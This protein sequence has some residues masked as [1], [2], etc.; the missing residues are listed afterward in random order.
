MSQHNSLIPLNEHLRNLYNEA[1]IQTGA[2]AIFFSSFEASE[3]VMRKLSEGDIRFKV[4][5]GRYDMQYETSYTIPAE[6]LE[7]LIASTLV[8]GQESLMLLNL[9]GEGF[10]MYNQFDANGEL[11]IE[12]LGEIITISKDDALQ[13]AAFTFDPEDGLYYGTVNKAA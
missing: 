3:V 2:V 5:L 4:L 1:R 10:L 13:R 12:R 11:R 8:D 7:W 6:H 9:Q